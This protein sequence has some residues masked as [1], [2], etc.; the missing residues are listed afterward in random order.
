MTVEAGQGQPSRLSRPVR[1][2][3]IVSASC[4]FAGLKPV[5]IFHPPPSADVYVRAKCK[6]SSIFSD[7]TGDIVVLAT[8][9]TTQ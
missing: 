4:M 7:S 5:Q 8:F 2:L 1:E 3:K 6:F 9:S